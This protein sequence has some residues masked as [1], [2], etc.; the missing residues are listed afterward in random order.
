[1]REVNSRSPLDGRY[2]RVGRRFRAPLRVTPG[3]RAEHPP[4][5][6]VAVAEADVSQPDQLHF[7]GEV[8]VGQDR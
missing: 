1:M 5:I 3:V 7:P 6:C 8:T 2:R 4:N